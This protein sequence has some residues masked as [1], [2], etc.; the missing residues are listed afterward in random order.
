MLDLISITEELHY[1]HYNQQ[2]LE[3]RKPGEPRPKK[4]DNLKL[5]F[6]EEALRK[7]FT[8]QV[9]Q[10]ELRLRQW[11]QH[12]SGVELKLEDHKAD[13]LYSSLR[14]VTVS[15]RISKPLTARSRTSRLSSTDSR[16]A[17]T[18]SAGDERLVCV[19]LLLWAL[20]PNVY[21]NP[22]LIMDIHSRFVC[23]LRD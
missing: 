4:G 11:E 15:T 7:R 9:K 6:K 17:I 12:V 10:E 19:S 21:P 18:V 22:N 14:S 2:Q 5:K 23:T 13:C 1:E 8:E 16:S 20:C 3:T